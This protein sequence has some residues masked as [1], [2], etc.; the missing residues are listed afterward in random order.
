M[1]ATC[2]GDTVLLRVEVNGNTNGGIFHMGS[3]DSIC[4][5]RLVKSPLCKAFCAVMVEN[6]ASACGK[7]EA[8]VNVDWKLCKVSHR[9]ACLDATALDGCI[10]MNFVGGNADMIIDF[11]LSQLCSWS[12]RA[13]GLVWRV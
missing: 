1:A 3:I 4:T 8:M 10:G 5:T 6:G 7:L 9:C 12:R 13:E 2:E 11:F